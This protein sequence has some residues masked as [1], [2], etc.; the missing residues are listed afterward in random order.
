MGLK[1]GIV[2]LP[3]VGKST[4][5]NALSDAGAE[6]AVNAVKES[7]GGESG[8]WGGVRESAKEAGTLGENAEDGQPLPGEVHATE[9]TRERRNRERR[10]DSRQQSS[11]EWDDFDG[12][13]FSRI[14]ENSELLRVDC[15]RFFRPLYPDRLETGHGW[16]MR[17]IHMVVWIRF[18]EVVEVVEVRFVRTGE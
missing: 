15:Q 13:S 7:C 12:I 14:S 2:G 9:C 1:C 5:F 11:G 4:L 16:S 3:N 17:R 18:V 6:A 8:E 10:G